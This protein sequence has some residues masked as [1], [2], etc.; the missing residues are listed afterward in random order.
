MLAQKKSTMFQFSH[1]L[2]MK[3]SRARRRSAKIFLPDFR[4]KPRLNWIIINTWTC[5][6]AAVS[7][8]TTLFLIPFISLAS[9]MDVSSRVSLSFS[10]GMNDEFYSVSWWSCRN[11]SLSGSQIELHL[12]GFWAFNNLLMSFQW[13]RK[14]FERVR[15]NWS[16]IDQRFLHD[17]SGLKNI[18]GDEIQLQSN[19]KFCGNFHFPFGAASNAQFS[20]NSVNNAIARSFVPWSRVP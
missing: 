9:I 14:C 5:S 2:I 6:T 13:T 18:A 20:R 3:H 1:R 4:E 19:W 15:Y 7:C 8:P 16:V 10:L 12:S 11:K 17:E